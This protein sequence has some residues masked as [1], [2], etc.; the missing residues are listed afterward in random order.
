[1]EFIKQED[2]DYDNEKMTEMKL[3]KIK[4][5]LSYQIYISKA[6]KIL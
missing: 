6:I 4:T 3:L 2:Y 1:M 5:S